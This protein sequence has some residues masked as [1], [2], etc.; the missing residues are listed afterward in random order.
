MFPTTILN[1]LQR[2]RIK[3]I[4]VYILKNQLFTFVLRFNSTDQFSSN[5]LVVAHLGANNRVSTKYTT[6]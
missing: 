4:F 5:S 2:N 3:F 6:Y 1:I